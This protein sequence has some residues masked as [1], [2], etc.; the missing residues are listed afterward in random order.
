MIDK[1]RLANLPHTNPYPVMCC[2]VDGSIQWGNDAAKQLQVSLKLNRL[3]DLVPHEHNELIEC[4]HQQNTEVRADV[5]LHRRTI[6]WVYTPAGQT[7]NLYGVETTANQ[8]N[9][10]SLAATPSVVSPITAPTIDAVFDF[11]HT[12]VAFID[13]ELRVLHLNNSTR[14]ILSQEGILLRK[15][16]CLLN[17]TNSNQSSSV[18]LAIAD[19]VKAVTHASAS[20]V[21]RQVFSIR[22]AK[23]DHFLEGMVI[24][25]CETTNKPLSEQSSAKVILFLFHPGSTA[26]GNPE[27]MRT[28]YDLTS[29]EAR[30][31]ARLS[32]GC[33]LHDAADQLGVK[34]GT[35]RTQLSQ[36]FRKTNTSRQPELVNRILTGAAGLSINK[37][38]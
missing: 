26:S 13:E 8:V 17:Q 19:A 28:L 10:P 25:W 6:S 15:G 9:K 11:I 14:N 16:Q 33:S 37:T 38:R 7:V 32:G 2:E 30:L 12:G 24:P 31:A 4:C 21:S 3:L 36:I 20:E 29:A 1:D 23:H 34:I 22:L 35:V 27:M 5:Q 18:L